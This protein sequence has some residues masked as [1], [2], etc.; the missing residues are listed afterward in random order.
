MEHY[1]SPVNILLVEDNPADAA[2][3]LEAFKQCRSH[4]NITVLPNGMEAL[5][6]L[7]SSTIKLPD[8]IL[9]DLNLP[10]W[11]GKNLLQEIKSDAVLKRIPVVVL[12]SSNA[13]N[14][15]MECY[16][17]HANCYVVKSLDVDQYFE[18]IR[19]IEKFWLDTALLPSMV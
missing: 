15:V 7:R 11:D 10:R 8:L 12:T 19:D 17:L 1:K 3:T 13:R 14:D 18:N 4:A 2:L 5:Y 9:L 6:Y 16:G